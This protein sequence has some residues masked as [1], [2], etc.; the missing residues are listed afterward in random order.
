MGTDHVVAR[1]ITEI[2]MCFSAFVFS[3]VCVTSS[4]RSFS[5][6]NLWWWVQPLLTCKLLQSHSNL[7]GNEIKAFSSPNE[8]LVI[9]TIL[10]HCFYYLLGKLTECSFGTRHLRN[11]APVFELDS[12]GLHLRDQT[13]QHSSV[14]GESSTL[15]R[16]RKLITL[17]RSF[18]IKMYH[19]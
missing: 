9:P 15:L 18:Y 10:F 17:D 2:I 13:H 12:T 4:R 3:L 19:H 16:D 7:L 8:S 14:Q 11:T 6:A 5:F 1:I